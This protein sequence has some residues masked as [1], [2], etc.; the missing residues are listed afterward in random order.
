M[1][2][3]ESDLRDVY[4][5]FEKLRQRAAGIPSDKLTTLQLLLER[6]AATVGAGSSAL[7][8]PTCDGV[9]NRKLTGRPSDVRLW[10]MKCRREVQEFVRDLQVRG[11]PVARAGAPAADGETSRPVG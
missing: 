7:R 8:C 3:T 9:L 6:G 11:G 4:S 2:L 1:E 5:T 10:C